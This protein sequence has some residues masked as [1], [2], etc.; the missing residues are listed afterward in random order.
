MLLVADTELKNVI[1]TK[2]RICQVNKPVAV[3]VAARRA[4]VKNSTYHQNRCLRT[5]A[6]MIR[7]CN[8]E[9]VQKE[10]RECHMKVEAVLRRKLR[11]QHAEF[12][13]I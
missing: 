2:R 9:L 4:V 11:N 6:C 12:M 10:K 8:R 13:G 3:E 1:S 7:T 5:M